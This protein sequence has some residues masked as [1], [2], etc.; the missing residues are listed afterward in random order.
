MRPILLVSALTS[1]RS[2]SPA[3]LTLLPPVIAAYTLPA[4]IMTAPPSRA[5]IIP[6]TPSQKSAAPAI[7]VV[8]KNCHFRTARNGL[9]AKDPRRCHANLMIVL[10]FVTMRQTVLRC[11]K[12]CSSIQTCN[13]GVELGQVRILDDE[14]TF[15]LVS[16]L[17]Q[18]LGAQFLG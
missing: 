18:D 7:T 6:S 16:C 3:V 17:D 8:A 10:S 15:T 12:N 13:Y 4:I 1:A 5:E 14:R 2:V 11:S 9:L